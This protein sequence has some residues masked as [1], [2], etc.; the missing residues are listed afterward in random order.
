M[1]FCL[2]LNISK[3][4]GVKTWAVNNSQ[5]PLDHAKQPVKDALKTTSKRVFQKTAEAA[6]S[7]IVNKIANK[8]T[9]FQKIHNR[10]IQKQLQMSMMKEYLKK[11]INLQ[12]KDRN[13]LM[14]WD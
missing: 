13:G 2:L 6:G 11:Y 12:K 10:I 9:R 7:L 3:D 8:I 4:I 1:D 14:I 5:K